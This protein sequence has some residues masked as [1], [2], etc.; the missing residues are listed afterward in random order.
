MLSYRKGTLNHYG[1]RLR[2]IGAESGTQLPGCDCWKV[3]RSH[4]RT[5]VSEIINLRRS[6]NS[7]KP[8]KVSSTVNSRGGSRVKITMRHAFLSL[9]YLSSRPHAKTFYTHTH[10]THTKRK[11]KPRK[12]PRTIYTIDRAAQRYDKINPTTAGGGG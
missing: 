3:G 11:T 2:G 1:E 6:S 4:E 7:V 12:H 8:W 9:S 10:K 5:R